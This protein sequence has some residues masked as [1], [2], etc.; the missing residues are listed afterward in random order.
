MEVDFL[1][2]RG[3]E[4]IAVEVKS[5]RTFTESWCKGLRAVASIP[6]LRRRIIVYPDGPQLKTQ[7]GIEVLP[8]ELFSDQ[9]VE[10]TMR[11]TRPPELRNRP[12]RSL[13]SV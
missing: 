11:R 12:P 10:G 8:F 3:P 13:G 6:G 9:L 7:D 1:L 4:L 5:G 2:Q